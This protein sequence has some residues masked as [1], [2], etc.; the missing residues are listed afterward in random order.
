LRKR[1]ALSVSTS[2]TSNPLS[3]SDTHSRGT[4]TAATLPLTNTTHRFLRHAAAIF[5]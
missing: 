1:L 2:A 5:Y 3:D 4:F